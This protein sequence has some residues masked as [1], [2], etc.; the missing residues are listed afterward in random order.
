MPTNYLHD[1]EPHLFMPSR[2]IRGR[3]RGYFQRGGKC[4]GVKAMRAVNGSN[5]E[6]D[7]QELAWKAENVWL[8]SVDTKGLGGGL[9]VCRETLLLL[10]SD[11]CLHLQFQQKTKM[12][13]KNHRNHTHPEITTV[14]FSGSFSHTPKIIPRPYR[15]LGHINPS[16]L[17]FPNK[18]NLCSFSKCSLL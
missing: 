16:C 7:Q 17:C 1:T 10:G 6:P 5:Y 18:G 9:I 8:H 3:W 4:E 11:S 15:G 13:S 2:S 14:N 12:E